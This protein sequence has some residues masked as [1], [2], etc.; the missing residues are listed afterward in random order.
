LK[1]TVFSWIAFLALGLSGCNK[2]APTSADAPPPPPPIG[3]GVAASADAGTRF[4]LWLISKQP[5]QKTVPTVQ[6]GKI[7]ADSLKD[8]ATGPLLTRLGMNEW[9][10]RVQWAWDDNGP[11]EPEAQ[12]EIV[13]QDA[14]YTTNSYSACVW[15]GSGLVGRVGRACVMQSYACYAAR[16]KMDDRALDVV[17]ATQM[18]SEAAS[19]AFHDAGASVVGEYLR[20]VKF[21]K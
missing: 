1:R 7:I 3:V 14:K 5:D 2:T 6:P 15:P 10:A 12:K 9:Q 21:C 8:V 20:T 4:E 18:Y 19:Q 17:L 16:I 13:K 11:L